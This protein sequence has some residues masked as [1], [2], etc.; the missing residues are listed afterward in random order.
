MPSGWAAKR[1]RMDL[2][3]VRDRPQHVLRRLSARLEIS[4]PVLGGRGRFD[5]DL[6]APDAL[7]AQGRACHRCRSCGMREDVKC[8]VS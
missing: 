7:R 5:A 4:G 2:Y 1:Y 8:P 3:Q 6:A